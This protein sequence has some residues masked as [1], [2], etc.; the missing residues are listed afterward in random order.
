MSVI[1]PSSPAAAATG[2]VGAPSCTTITC[3]AVPSAFTSRRKRS[4]DSS[5]SCSTATTVVIRASLS[6]SAGPMA[7][8]GGS[9]Q[10][11]MQAS[12]SSMLSR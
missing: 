3:T 8:K 1:S 9:W 4:R 12:T 5:Q 6:N 11:S 2:R 10:G 7:A